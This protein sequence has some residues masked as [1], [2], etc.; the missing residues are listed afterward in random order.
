MSHKQGVAFK[1]RAQEHNGPECDIS[2]VCHIKSE[3]L[4]F[5]G[6]SQY[7]TNVTLTGSLIYTQGKQ[8]YAIYYMLNLLVHI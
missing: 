1:R 4:K 3:E 5:P 8:L 2:M 7:I 6:M